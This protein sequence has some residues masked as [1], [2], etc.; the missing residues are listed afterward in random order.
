LCHELGYAVRE[1]EVAMVKWTEKQKECGM[2]VAPSVFEKVR[3]NWRMETPIGHFWTCLQYLL[4]L[5]LLTSGRVRK[6]MMMKPVRRTATHQKMN[7]SLVL[8]RLEREIL[9]T[10]G[11]ALHGR[12]SAAVAL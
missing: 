9:S 6:V 5:I 8:S 10:F 2:A 12:E 3:E 4:S 1:D 7:E 11:I